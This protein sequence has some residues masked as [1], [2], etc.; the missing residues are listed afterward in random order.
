MAGLFSN[1]GSHTLYDLPGF[2]KT[3]VISGSAG[4]KDYADALAKQLEQQSGLILV[5]H[6]YGGRVAVQMAA[7]YPEKVKA[8]ILIGGAGL[9]RRR[10]IWF[11]ARAFILRTIGQLARFSDDLFK[12]R[13]RK[14]YIARFGSSDYKNAGKLR[15]TLVSA[16]NEDLSTAARKTQC[17]TLLIYGS[18]DTETPPEIG[19]K[20]E[21]LFPIARYEEL[22]GYGHNDILSRGAYQCE[23]LMKAFLKD[24]GND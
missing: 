24:L 17:P 1:T 12:T 21:T 4:T 7:H 19:Q 6:S 10:S 9:K 23:A 11:R 18:E 3:P 22:A 15:S 13:F 8:I 16:V 5:G 14:K 20:Y 2:G